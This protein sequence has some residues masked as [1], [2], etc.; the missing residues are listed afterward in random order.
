MELSANQ[1]ADIIIKNIEKYGD[2]DCN[3]LLITD[4]IDDV[5]NTLD[6]MRL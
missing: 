6:N 4:T 5:I 1:I 2:T 3:I